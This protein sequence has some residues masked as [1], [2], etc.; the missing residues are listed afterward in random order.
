MSDAL[1]PVVAQRIKQTHRLLLAVTEDLAADAFCRR[2]ATTAP[3]IGWHLW[4]ISRW[5]DRVQA[6]FPNRPFEP[7][8]RADRAQQIW[9]REG[10]ALRWGL[11]PKALGI[12]ETGSGMDDDTAAT[13]PLV[14]QD[15]LLDYARRSFSALEE[16]LLAVQAPE[17]AASRNSVMEFRIDPQSKELSDAPGAETTVA[18]DFGFHL[19]HGGRHLGMI[20][21][22]RGV[23]AIKGTATV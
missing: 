15:R 8:W 3:P 23:V 22:L 10:L 14:G 18:G 21:A 6:S 13:I 1:L 11:V 2:P 16:A 9:C 20:E 19:S 5:A 17:L 4:H 7:G 12:L